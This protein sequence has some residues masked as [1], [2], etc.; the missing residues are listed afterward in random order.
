MPYGVVL[1]LRMCGTKASE[2]VQKMTCHSDLFFDIWSTLVESLDDA[3]LEET[4]VTLKRIWTRRNDFCHGKVFTHPTRIYQQAIE[5]L[6]NFKETTTTFKGTKRQVGTAVHKWS[7]PSQNNFKLN[8]DAAVKAKERRIGIGVIVRDYQGQV[9][10]TVRA[11]RPLR[12][13]P[14]DAEAYGL[15]TTVVFC[16][17]LGL[18]QICLEGDAKYVVDVL[19]SKALNWRLGGCLI[20]D[21]RRVLNSSVDW[22]ATHILERQTW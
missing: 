10:G 19:Q 13:T 16:K 7:K 14:F 22:T 17:E 5:E 20:E 12:G 11:Q 4:A 6:S 8:W 18:Q 15:L 1:L 21:A 9:I 3:E 2:K